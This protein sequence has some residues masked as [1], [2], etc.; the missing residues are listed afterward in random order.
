MTLLKHYKEILKAEGFSNGRPFIN[1]VIIAMDDCWRDVNVFVVDAPTGYGKTL[2]SMTLAKYSVEEEFKAIVAYPLRTLLEDQLRSFR[3]VFSKLRVGD[4][5]GIDDEVV[6]ARYMGH[7]GSRYLVKPV[8]LT[9]VDMLSMMVAGVPPEDLKKVSKALITWTSRDS[10]GHYIF[11]WGVSLSSN[12][13]V[14]EVHLIADSPK[15]LDFIRFL[16]EVAVEAGTHIVL[17]S[18][19]LT[20]TFLKAVIPPKLKEGKI[21]VFRFADYVRNTGREDSFILDRLSKHYRIYLKPTR[22]GELNEVVVG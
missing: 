10:L 11:S 7:F 13:V 8:T 3:E 6:E 14:D 21:K 22:E 12:I 20:D 19:T 15:G 17:M 18:A 16:V 2:V 5:L 1:N 9:T 4:K